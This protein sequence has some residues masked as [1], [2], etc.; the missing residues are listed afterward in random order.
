MIEGSEGGMHQHQQQAGHL[1]DGV[2][3]TEMRSGLLKAARCYRR[4]IAAFNEFPAMNKGFIKNEAHHY[5]EP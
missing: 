3:H 5:R 4:R 1:I 2:S